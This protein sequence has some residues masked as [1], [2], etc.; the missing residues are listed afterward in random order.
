LYDQQDEPIVSKRSVIVWSRK[1]GGHDYPAARHYLSLLYPRNKVA[2]IVAQLR[3]AKLSQFQAKD[4]FRASQLPAL[5]DSDFHVRKDRN[6][7][8]KGAALAPILLVRDPEHG[9]VIIADG[10][11]RLCAVYDFD[12]D[13][14]VQCKIV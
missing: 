1:N 7:I 9:R 2:K 6:R 12:E 10:Y 13:A 4:I 14:V 8:R 3:R 5:T 11:H